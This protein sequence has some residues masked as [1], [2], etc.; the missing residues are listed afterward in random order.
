MCLTLGHISIQAENAQNI[1]SKSINTGLILSYR[2]Y[3]IW[4]CVFNFP[5]FSWP[6]NSKKTVVS[7]SSQLNTNVQNLMCFVYFVVGK[8]EVNVVLY[9]SITRMFSTQ[10]IQY[11]FSVYLTQYT[12]LYVTIHPVEMLKIKTYTKTY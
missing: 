9:C 10:A 8:N 6:V 5:C 3:F 11:T 7:F 4:L 12:H 1:N 2:H